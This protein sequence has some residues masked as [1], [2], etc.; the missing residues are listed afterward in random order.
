MTRVEKVFACWKANLADAHLSC[1]VGQQ[2]AVKG[3]FHSHSNVPSRLHKHI[4]PRRADES[5]KK[6]RRLPNK[7]ERWIFFTAMDFNYMLSGA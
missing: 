4:F 1:V 7:T 2:A 6:H 5:C 3:Y